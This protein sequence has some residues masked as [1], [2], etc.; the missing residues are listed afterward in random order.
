MLTGVMKT[1]Q[2][3]ALNKTVAKQVWFYFSRGPTR[4]GYAGTI[5]NLQIVLNIQKDTC[6][7]FPNQKNPEIEN[8]KPKEILRTSLSLEIRSTPLGS[9]KIT[10]YTPGH[11]ADY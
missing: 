6:Q 8:F 3:K 5:T 4:P 7:N 11:F 2:C 1:M 9:L 10:I